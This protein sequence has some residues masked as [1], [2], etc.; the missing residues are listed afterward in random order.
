MHLGLLQTLPT[1]GIRLLTQ[2]NPA[3]AVNPQYYCDEDLEG[4]RICV[5][6]SL[7]AA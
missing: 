3:A 4:L 5:S 1:L 2:S 6:A 7:I